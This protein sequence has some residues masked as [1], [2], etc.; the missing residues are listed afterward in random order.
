MPPPHSSRLGRTLA[1]SAL[2]VAASPAPSPCSV[3]PFQ[4]THALLRM[5][6]VVRL[7]N[8]PLPEPQLPLS[9]T[10]YSPS[11]KV[12]V[13]QQCLSVDSK[14]TVCARLAPGESV[15]REDVFTQLRPLM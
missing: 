3:L 6:E 2:D 10:P 4:L 13:L 9:V 1:A 15:L 5:P 12:Y 11:P 7:L 8:H 14:L